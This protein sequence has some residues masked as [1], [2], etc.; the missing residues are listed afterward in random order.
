MAKKNKNTDIKISNNG[1]IDIDINTDDKYKNILIIGNTIGFFGYILKEDNQRHMFKLD[2]DKT[3]SATYDRL[4]WLYESLVSGTEFTI[5]GNTDTIDYYTRIFDFLYY[6]DGKPNHDFNYKKQLKCKKFFNDKDYIPFIEKMINKN[7]KYD[8]IIQNPPYS[9]SLHLEFLK[10]GLELL[11]KDNGKMT[12]IE[13][14]TFLISLRQTRNVLT[15]YNEIKLLLD[16]HVYRINIE[17][18]NKEFN[19]SVHTPFSITYI[20][21]SK[22]YNNIEFNC[23]GYVSNINTLNDCNLVGNYNIIQSIINKVKNYGDTMKNHIYN[24]KK[25]IINKDTYYC[26]Y[27]NMLDGFSTIDSR[28]GGYKINSSWLSHKNGIYLRS[29][30]YSSYHHNRN[31]ITNKILCKCDAGNHLTDKPA[32][33]LYGTKQELENWKYFIFN[34][35]LPLFINI[36]LTFDHSNGSKDTLPWLTDRRYTDEEINKLFNFTEEEINFIDKTLKK[37]ERHSPWFRRYICGKDSVPDEEV[38]KFI[39]SL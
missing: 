31:E 20:D 28:G 10:K 30:L 8:Y 39:D 25:T 16:K 11:K 27:A 4:A 14:A 33:C 36:C 21:F 35:R 23:F 32:D 5:I 13:P 2:D 7:M 18:L 15:I 9:G 1:F 34:N 22:E 12:I 29:Y 24:K 3:N 37:Y 19:T 6:T 26:K 17:N 38:Q